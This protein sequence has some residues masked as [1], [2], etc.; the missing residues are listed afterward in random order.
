M[1]PLPAA[2]GGT[3]L[4]AWR[5]DRDLYSGSWNSGEGAYQAGGRWNSKG[6]RAVYCSLDPATAI[7]EVAVHKTFHTLDLVPHVLTSLAIGRPDDVHIVRPQSIPNREWLRPGIPTVEQ[8]Q[9]GDRLLAQHKF[10][11][12]PSAVS[13][14]SWNLVFIATN[15]AQAYRLD[16]QQP[17]VLD[18]RLNPPTA[19]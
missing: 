16:T 19:S 2:L 17:L 5:I 3:G 1:T 14:M 7:L 12:I 15:A 9:F 13:T 10:I 8:Q 6:I 18:N 11:A 4:I